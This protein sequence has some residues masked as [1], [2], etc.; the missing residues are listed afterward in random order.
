MHRE[1]TRSEFCD[2][3]D[4][5]RTSHPRCCSVCANDILPPAGN[6]DFLSFAALEERTSLIPSANHRSSFDGSPGLF[7]VASQ[8]SRHV[9]R[10]HGW[11][12]DERPTQDLQFCRSANTCRGGMPA[13]ALAS[14]C[15]CD[16]K[17]RTSAPEATR[18]LGER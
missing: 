8:C 9:K 2:C 12:G 16:R 11:F 10:P 18:R 15:A 17:P 4:Y 7:C 13:I 6:P 14:A 3:A 1:T 5:H